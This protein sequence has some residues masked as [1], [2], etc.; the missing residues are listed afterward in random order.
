MEWITWL[1]PTV[2]KKLNNIFVIAHNIIIWF[3]LVTKLIN[4]IINMALG[5]VIQ[6]SLVRCCAALRNCLHTQSSHEGPV[7]RS[8]CMNP[9]CPPRGVMAM[10]VIG[11]LSIGD[12]GSA[13]QEE[14]ES[15]IGGGSLL[16]L[17]LGRPTKKLNEIGRRGGGEKREWHVERS[18]AKYRHRQLRICY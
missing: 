14:K 10:A 11:L 4:T 13:T 15:N 3:A 7:G 12:K 8:P 17:S 2:T 18:Q 9:M 1:N 6:S 5:P 16:K